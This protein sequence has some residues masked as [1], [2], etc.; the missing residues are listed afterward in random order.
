MSGGDLNTSL[1]VV[2]QEI[3][4]FHAHAETAPKDVSKKEVD[5]LIKTIK[6]TFEQF[7]EGK[8]ES[9]VTTQVNRGLVKDVNQA[10]QNLFAFLRTNPGLNP[11]LTKMI[12]SLVGIQLKRQE[13]EF[14]K[15]RTKKRRSATA[16]H[17]KIVAKVEKAHKGGLNK[18]G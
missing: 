6:T 4:A 12:S 7:P 13:E 14:N 3:E 15:E 18:G 10:L 8:M 16:P 17:L 2:R 9:N 11:G 1:R 5:N